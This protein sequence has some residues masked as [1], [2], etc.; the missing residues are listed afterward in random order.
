MG[1]TLPLTAIRKGGQEIAIELSLSAVQL[2]GEW[3]A[4]GVTRDVSER[5]QL[6]EELKRSKLAAEDAN[7]AKSEFLAAMSHELRTPLNSMLGMV[8]L[9]QETSLTPEQAAYLQTFSASGGQLRDIINDILDFSRIEAGRVEFESKPFN[10]LK[11]VGEVCSII[12]PTAIKKGLR[13]S[14]RV[15]ANLEPHRLGAPLLI[16]QILL[17]LLANA[18]KFTLEGKVELSVA[19]SPGE[20]DGVSFTVRDTGVGI[21]EDKR[22]IVFEH[23]SQADSSKTRRFGGAGLG[24]AISRK[25]VLAMHGSIRLDSELD[26]GTSFLVRLPLPRAVS[27]AS[28]PAPLKEELLQGVRILVVEDAASNRQ[29]LDLFLRRSG[30]EYDFAEHGRKAVELFEASRYDVVLM[31]IEMPEMDGLEATR[32]IRRWEQQSGR[33]PTP[34]VALTAHAFEDFRKDV[35]EAGCDEFLTKP[36]RKDNLIE[37][38]RRFAPRT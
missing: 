23:F 31:D 32:L 7:R 5:V 9:L 34:V 21:P 28:K 37:V 26:V 16:K 24:L 35:L 19:S 4:V 10:L 12:A 27:E 36:I 25:L 33:E 15:E 18:V 11:I 29:L 17:N 1:R 6:E 3:C 8:E 38:L 22:E 2:G 20:P 14:R 30:A 13:F